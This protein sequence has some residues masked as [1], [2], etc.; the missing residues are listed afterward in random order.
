MK[1]LILTILRLCVSAAYAV[2]KLFVR[3]KNRIVFLSRQS[4]E[5]SADFLALAS[6]IKRQSPDTDI[7]C[8]CRLGLKNE[9]GLSYI[10]LML[11][12]LVALAGS[13]ACVTESFC[14]PISLPRHRKSLRIVQIWHSMVAIKKF[15]WQTVGTEEG[16]SQ[17]MAEGMRMHR[18]YDY[19]ICGSDYMRQFF[20][21]AMRQDV[22]TVLPLGSPHADILLAMDRGSARE[23]AQEL[24]PQLCGRKLVL[25]APTMRRNEAVDCGGLIRAFDYQNACLMIKLHPLDRDTVVEDER[26]ILDDRMSTTQAICAADVVISDYSGVC[27]DASLLDI[28]VLFYTPDVDRYSKRC[29]LNFIP[30]ELFP[31]ITFSGAE[32][33]VALLDKDIPACETMRVRELLAGGCDS[34]STE[35]IASLL[36]SSE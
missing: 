1:K 33:L 28:P 20:A 3:P 25:Y 6:E 21:E 29:G 10:P 14:P 30:E 32:E 27:A 5:P 12:Q 2:I 24:Y 8:Y 23:R 11:K 7:S 9:M 19:V 4:D 31:N 15:G 35:R 22:D 13:R 34:H 36:L 17:V 26:V 16:S 18:G